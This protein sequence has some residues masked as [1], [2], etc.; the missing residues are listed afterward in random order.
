MSA[1]AEIIAA[2]ESRLPEQTNAYR[3]SDGTTWP[4]IFIDALADRLLVSVR[5]TAVPRNLKEQL[6]ATSRPVYL[7]RLDKDVKEAPIHFVGPQA[8]LRF[9]IQENGVRYIMDMNAGYSQGIFLDQRDNRATVRG[10]CSAG[11]RLLNTFSYT[12]AFSV[13]AALAGATTTT[14]DLA[15][16]CLT[17]C[18]ENM[19]RNGIDASQHYFCKGDTLH[20]LDRFARQGRTFDAIVLDPPTFSRDEKGRIWRVEKDY[21]SLVAKAMACLAPGGWLL[22]TTNCRKVSHAQ[23]R[24]LVAS[25]AP[26]AS[27]TASPMT[28]DFDGEDYLKTLWVNN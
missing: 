22:C 27:I 17:W 1:L 23:F 26:G 16:P 19:E 24:A 7:K 4:G 6:I 2:R 3:V 12:G 8:E 20:W 5:D 10:K 18:R 15:Q 13:C 28:F 11:M 14:L 9:E 25:G 21:G